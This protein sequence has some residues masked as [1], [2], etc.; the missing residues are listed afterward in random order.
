MKQNNFLRS[1]LF[2]WPVK[3]LSLVFAISLYLVVAFAVSPEREVVLPLQVIVPRGFIAA[4]SFPQTVT[5][6]IS[7][8]DRII[9]RIEP[10]LLVVSVD[11]SF[12]NAEGVASA[13]ILIS[14]KDSPLV[15][16]VVYSVE[17]EVLRVFFIKS[18]ADEP[19]VNATENVG[20]IEL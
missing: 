6:T 10:S 4:S 5:V 1:V 19:V 14:F 13:P 3:I 7:G 11:F 16:R 15:S 18:K 9:H 8:E 12:V 20:P 2:N 17:P